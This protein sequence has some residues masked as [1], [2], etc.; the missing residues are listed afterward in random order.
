MPDALRDPRIII[1]AAALVGLW[2]LTRK[3]VAAAA[4]RAAVEAAEGVAVGVV[5]GIGGALGVPTTDADAC[6]LALADGRMMDASFA[7]PAP[8]YLSVAVMGRPDAAAEALKNRRAVEG[9]YAIN[10]RERN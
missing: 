4:G 6:T 8:R 7:C 3:G 5:E 2:V 9:R 10:P 1:A